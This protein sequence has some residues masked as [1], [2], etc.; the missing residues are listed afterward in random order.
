VTITPTPPPPPQLSPDGQWWWNG[1][2]W[3]SSNANRDPA[4]VG[5]AGPQIA[6]NGNTATHRGSGIG[7][8]TSLLHRRIPKAILVAAA[9]VAVL[10]GLGVKAVDDKNN[11]DSKSACRETALLQ[12]TDPAAC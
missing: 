7:D 12:N 2:G 11:A 1:L 4:H 9:L 5:A 10:A 6:T 8:A 3:V